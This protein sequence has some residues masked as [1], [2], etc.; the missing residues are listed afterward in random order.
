[1]P[2]LSVVLSTLGNYDVLEQVLRA[3]ERQ[4][5]S[6]DRWELL[7]AVDSADPEPDRV[8]GLVRRGRLP[9]RLVR[10]R[11]PGLSAN[12]NAGVAESR[13]PLVL[14]TDNDTRPVP[15]LLA[16]HL[17]WH[18]RHPAPEV[19][20]LGLI[21]WAPELKITPF[22]RWLDRG[23]QFDYGGIDGIEAGWGRLYGGNSS[24]K[25]ELIE[26]V[27]GWDAE[28][29]PYLYEDIDFGYRA[30]GHGLRVLFN[31]AAVVDHI[32]FDAALEFW[33]RKVVRLAHTE[34]DFITKHPELEPWFFRIFAEAAARPR[35]RG[36]GV[37]AC[38]FIPKSVPVLGPYVWTSAELYWK[39]QL[40]GPFLEAW[41]EAEA[42]ART[43][44]PGELSRAQVGASAPEGPVSSGGS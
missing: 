30:S 3:Y 35:A 36:R 38:R 33:R 21:R 1:M 6:T 11:R 31:E 7:V 13:A 23:I 2:E 19:A 44:P 18:R 10:G 37:S 14:I 32:R 41:A 5:L 24:L 9:A 16:Q 15:E 29:L 26:R 20:V 8:E 40:A 39:Q 27:G 43:G 34:H 25:R 17:E 12:R 42:G 28:R 22:M 4:T